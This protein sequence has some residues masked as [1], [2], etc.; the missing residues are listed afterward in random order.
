M[1]CK[2]APA[3]ASQERVCTALPSA[4]QIN[5]LINP[6]SSLLQE[7]DVKYRFAG[8]N[9]SRA[10]EIA[11]RE[12]FVP[13]AGAGWERQKQPWLPLG[14]ARVARAQVSVPLGQL[15][16]QSLASATHSVYG[17]IPGD[18]PRTA[19][20]ASRRRPSKH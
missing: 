17:H 14:P 20:L 5:G 19:R 16:A 8:A 11:E 2:T 1:R 9:G 4:R 15:V 13:G 12:G 18:L 3:L 6:I 10:G 7:N